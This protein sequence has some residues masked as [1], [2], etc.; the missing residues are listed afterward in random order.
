M[1]FIIENRGVTLDGLWG[2]K[3]HGDPAVLPPGRAEPSH[4]MFRTSNL[5]PTPNSPRIV[6]RCCGDGPTT[7]YRL[8]LHEVQSSTG[9][10]RAVGNQQVLGNASIRNHDKELIAHPDRDEWPIRLSPGAQSALGVPTED[11]VTKRWSGRNGVAI[12]VFD[13]SPEDEG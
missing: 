4:L 2:E 6:V 12:L 9:E 5:S 8:V 10:D 3:L 7:K 13:V 1:G 11:S